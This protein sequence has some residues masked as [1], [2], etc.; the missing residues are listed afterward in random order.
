ASPWRKQSCHVISLCFGCAPAKQ[1]LPEL[2][3]LVGVIRHDSLGRV[4][5]AEPLLPRGQ[6]RRPR[7]VNQP[8][9]DQLVDRREPPE[10]A[11]EHDVDEP[12]AVAAEERLPLGALPERAL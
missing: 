7:R 8:A 12:D 6:R 2:E 9:T 3:Q 4:G 10:V 1:G 11:A 5:G